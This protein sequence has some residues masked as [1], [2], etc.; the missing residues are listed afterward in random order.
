MQDEPIRTP[1]DPERFAELKTYYDAD[2]LAV[3]VGVY[4][5]TTPES[6]AALRAAADDGDLPG[7]REAAHRL[8]GGSLALGALRLAEA[9]G[10]VERAN[11][12]GAPGPV[13]AVEAAWR[14][15]RDALFAELG[16]GG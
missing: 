12:E 14:E 2:E 11:A 16:G 10:A 8:R 7:L 4:L 3:L 9:A 1:L 6:V 15:L 13:E 5:E